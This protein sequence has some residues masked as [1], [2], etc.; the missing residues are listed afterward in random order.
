VPRRKLLVVL[1]GLA[2]VVAAGAVVLWP[3]QD[4]ISRQ[5]LERIIERNDQIGSGG[6]PRSTWRSLNRTT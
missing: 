1:A 2:V 3:R 6:Y 5:N 4:R